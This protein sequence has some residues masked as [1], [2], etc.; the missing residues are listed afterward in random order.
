M[1]IIVRKGVHARVARIVRAEQQERADANLEKEVK[2]DPVWRT[3]RLTKQT[4][5]FG[6]RV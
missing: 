4:F 1:K 3:D 6:M 5:G 2:P